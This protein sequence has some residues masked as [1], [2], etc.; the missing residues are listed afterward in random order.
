L[1][2]VVVGAGI[3]GL[4]AAWELARAG[5]ETVVVDPDPAGGATAAAA[6]MLAA[7]TEFHYQEPHLLGLS[8]PA[9]AGWPAWAAQ[10]EAASGL[11]TG[12]RPGGTLVVAADAGD[13][14]ALADLRAAQA[15][16]GLAIE[17]TTTREARAAEPLLAPRLA[18][19]FRAV[20]DHQTDP[21]RTAAALLAA[22]E[23]L[24]NARLVAARAVRCGAGADPF[25][26]Y[27]GGRLACDEV[28]LATGGGT[29]RTGVSG[30]GLVLEGLP[31]P[32]RLPV[33]P[34][35]GDV[36]RLRTVPGGPQLSGNVIRGLVGG[37]SVY[38]VPRA[39]GEVVVGAT[40]REDGRAGVGAGGVHRLLRDALRL[41]P[42][43]GELD[44]A[45]TMARARPA[46][47]DN[48]PLLGRAAPGL[49]VAVGFHRHG[50]L[51][52]AAA[53]AAV[54]AL[55]GVPAPS[56]SAPF[57]TAPLDPAPF[58]PWRFS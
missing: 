40:E 39:D 17:E 23:A 5:V 30:E 38:I 56:G 52:S 24:P 26:E 54:A 43:L 20:G 25:V 6:G 37:H 58:D 34:V 47:P 35:Y 1:R 11:S 9:A 36:L 21:R 50:V 49:V 31:A 44:L 32:L 29:V 7:V 51:L 18:G 45:E 16:L 42:A 14:A 15:A 22:L 41:M 13:R 12:F 3:I 4:S 8:L 27:D 10:L 55:A 2:C 28:V 46:T 19:A 53:A 48:L 57:E 33:R